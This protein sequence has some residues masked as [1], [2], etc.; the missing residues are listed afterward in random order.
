MLCHC[1]YEQTRKT[2]EKEDT[3]NFQVPQIVRNSVRDWWVPVSRRLLEL[4]SVAEARIWA[5]ISGFWTNTVQ[6]LT[7]SQSAGISRY[8]QHRPMTALVIAGSSQD[9]RLLNG[10]A[11]DPARLLI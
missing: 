11:P 6:T 8:L 7:R 3:L 4:P 9:E 2:G 5:L 10:V 1:H